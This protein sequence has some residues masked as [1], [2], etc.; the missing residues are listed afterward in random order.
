MVS[1]YKK[2][3][4]TYISYME[5][6]NGVGNL[7]GPIF[8]TILYMAGGFKGPFWGVAFVATATIIY[9]QMKVKQSK[10]DQANSEEDQEEETPT[11]NTLSLFQIL[12]VPRSFF[13][14]FFQ[15]MASFSGQY[16]NPMFASYLD[17]QGHST[18][19]I[20][21]VLSLGAVS[22]GL[23]IPLVA[24]FN[25]R[26]EKRGIIVLGTL[27]YG[28]GINTTG[29]E[30]YF[31]SKNDIDGLVIVGVILLGV[32]LCNI[33]IPVIPETLEGIEKST[34][35]GKYDKEIL[36]NNISGY[37]IVICGIGETIGPFTSSLLQAK[38]DYSLQECQRM[39]GVA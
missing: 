18:K 31:G 15:F 32:G 25:K 4:M 9:S 19:F 1:S 39:L 23:G 16:N 11:A 34:K 36:Y 38:Y 13:A 10:Q 33:V 8:G 12:S 6:L 27:I 2:N 30:I 20:A 35:F 28:I 21:F 37:Y 5:A 26:I 22:Y 3:R 7:T 14:L 29:S 17:Q 24:F